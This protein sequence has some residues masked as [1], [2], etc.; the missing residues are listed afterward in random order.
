MTTPQPHLQPGTGQGVNS[1]KSR[2]WKDDQPT[3]P[4]TEPHPLQLD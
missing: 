1:R 2:P 3:D 4:A